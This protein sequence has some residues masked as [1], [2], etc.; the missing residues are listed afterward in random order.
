L[1]DCAC[2]CVVC[3]WERERDLRRWVSFLTVLVDQVSIE[4]DT[5]LCKS[6][7]CSVVLVMHCVWVYLWF[8][9]ESAS[10]N[11]PSDFQT[12][13]L[14]FSPYTF[15]RLHIVRLGVALPSVTLS[16]LS[17]S[18]PTHAHTQLNLYNCCL[19]TQKVTTR[20][21]VPPPSF[22]P[23]SLPR[24]THVFQSHPLL[25]GITVLY[26]TKRYS[27]YLP[28]VSLSF[29]HAQSVPVIS[30]YLHWHP[31]YHLSTCVQLSRIRASQTLARTHRDISSDQLSSPIS[32]QVDLVTVSLRVS[33]YTTSPSRRIS[34]SWA[35]E[36]TPSHPQS[37]I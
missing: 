15:L 3:V 34:L 11:G 6:A 35:W 13:T 8:Y 1:I 24:W 29:W 2:V 33:M 30:D 26:N 17:S 7:Q 20:S 21:L 32:P 22:V 31:P 27:Q 16:P 12:K 10:M 14:H 28:R 5:Q 18:P 19:S 36:G 25:S 4:V 9:P 23:P 37:N